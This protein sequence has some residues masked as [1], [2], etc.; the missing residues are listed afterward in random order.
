VWGYNSKPLH[1]AW[2]EIDKTHK[3]CKKLMGVPNCAAIRF[4]EMEVGRESM[5]GKC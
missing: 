3:F 2:K 1:E 5:R 4:A